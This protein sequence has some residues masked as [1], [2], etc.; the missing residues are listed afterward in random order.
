MPRFDGTGP[1]GNGPMTGWRRGQCALPNSNQ[2][3]SN[4]SARRGVGQGGS[5]QGCGAGRCMGGQRGTNF[6]NRSSKITP[7]AE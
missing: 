2:E 6:K 4:Q 7:D 5:P 1:T 3:Q